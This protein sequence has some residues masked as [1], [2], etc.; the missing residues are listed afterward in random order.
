MAAFL[1]SILEKGKTQASYPAIKHAPVSFFISAC[2]FRWRFP[3]Y[4][5]FYPISTPSLH[6]VGEMD[7]IV[8]E[9]RTTALVECCGDATVIKH[10]GGHFV[11]S[12]AKFRQEI[13]EF[14]QRFKMSEDDYEGLI[15]Q[16][17][18]TLVERMV[19]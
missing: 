8:A 13:I 7:F 16:K 1:A 19:L 4:D 15:G 18:S 11:P 9:D 10:P 2:G 14:I 17:S 6:L 5:E 12:S 3:Q